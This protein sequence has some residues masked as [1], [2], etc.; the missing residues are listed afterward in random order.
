MPRPPKSIT[1]DD[2]DML[3]QHLARLLADSA[4]AVDVVSGSL[5]KAAKAF[6]SVG[7]SPD[8]LDIW[9]SNWLTPLGRRRMWA[10]LRQSSYKKRQGM[11]VLMVTDDA[12]SALSKS[13]KRHQMTFSEAILYLTKKAK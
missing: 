6:E 13:A 4:R 1:A 7:N 5:Q 11:R 3:H 12:Y 8:L 2:F 9:V 10:T